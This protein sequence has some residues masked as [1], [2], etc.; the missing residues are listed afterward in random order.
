MS[1][2]GA[3][4][5]FGDLPEHLQRPPEVVE[6][7]RRVARRPARRPARQRARREDHVVRLRRSCT[8]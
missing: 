1:A 5:C 2:R 4:C 8:G 7:Q 6:P 3:S